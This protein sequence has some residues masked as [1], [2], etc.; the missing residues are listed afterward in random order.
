MAQ[1]AAQNSRVLPTKIRRRV[2]GTLTAATAALLTCPATKKYEIISILLSEYSNN[3]RTAKIRQVATG[4]TEADTNNLYTD[5]PLA[6]KETIRLEGGGAD[7]PLTVL[8][9]GDTLKGLASAATSVNYLIIY[10]E[11]R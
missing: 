11:E 5:V 9:G 4:D 10:D 6:A 2:R 1:S 7:D 3:A 8:E